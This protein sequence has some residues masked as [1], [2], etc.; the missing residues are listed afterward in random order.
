MSESVDLKSDNKPFSLYLYP[1]RRFLRLGGMSIQDI[2][3]L[4]YQT[5]AVYPLISTSRAGLLSPRGE[6]VIHI[7]T[8]PPTPPFMACRA[9]TGEAGSA[10][11]RRYV[12][13]GPDAK[14]SAD[15]VIKITARPSV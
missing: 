11:G 2:G 9:H 14:N 3:F 4:S 5:F 13:Y 10:C 15:P 7:F 1:D 8:V 6:I 12:D